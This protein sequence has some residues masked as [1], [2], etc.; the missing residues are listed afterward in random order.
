MIKNVYRFIPLIK[1]MFKAI[2]SIKHNQV[3]SLG[4]I[5][6]LKT[7]VLIRKNF[8]RCFKRQFISQFFLAVF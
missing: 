8:L 2:T 5:V 6:K 3:M 7:N 4:N 1:A